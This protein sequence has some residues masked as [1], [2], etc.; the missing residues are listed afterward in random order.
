MVIPIGSLCNVLGN[1]KVSSCI[2]YGSICVKIDSLML[3]LLQVQK[4]LSNLSRY[5][6]EILAWLWQKLP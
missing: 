3:R 6:K 1:F 5:N 2:T 4:L